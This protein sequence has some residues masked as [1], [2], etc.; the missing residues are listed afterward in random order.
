MPLVRE[1]KQIIAAFVP[2]MAEH[3]VDCLVLIMPIHAS[4]IDNMHVCFYI[5]CHGLYQR[6]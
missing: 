6:W 4:M 3:P 2:M 1:V 5:D